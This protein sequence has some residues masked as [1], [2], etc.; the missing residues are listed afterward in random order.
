MWL[1]NLPSK[2][3]SPWRWHSSMVL[4][5]NF[6]ECCQIDHKGVD[7]KLY[8]QDFIME[9]EF[10]IAFRTWAHKLIFWHIRYPVTCDWQI[11]QYCT[12]YRKCFEHTMITSEV[13]DSLPEVSEVLWGPFPLYHCHLILVHSFS[14][15]IQCHSVPLAIWSL[16][17][18]SS[19][20]LL[21]YQKTLCFIWATIVSN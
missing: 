20:I 13:E 3:T 14:F 8:F 1:C 18:A 7:N 12:V 10:Y 5:W 4:P 9:I 16:S 19:R 17:K 2:A 15:A 21:L 11:D 6:S